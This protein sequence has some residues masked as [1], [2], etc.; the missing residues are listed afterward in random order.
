MSSAPHE[1]SSRTCFNGKARALD[2][3]FLGPQGATRG[4][5]TENLK[6]KKR[7]IQNVFFFFSIV[8]VN[9]RNK[10]YV[11]FKCLQFTLSGSDRVN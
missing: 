3:R 8:N 1:A 10:S 5:S 6:K 2:Q 7:I 4:G 9:L 11:L